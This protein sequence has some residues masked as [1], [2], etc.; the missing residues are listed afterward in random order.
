MRVDWVMVGLYV[1]LLAF[2]F[3]GGV[4]LTGNYIEGQIIEHSCAYHHPETGDFTWRD[5][6]AQ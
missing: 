2:A 5:D 3:I 4:V 1:A 6:D